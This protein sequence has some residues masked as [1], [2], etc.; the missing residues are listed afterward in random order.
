MDEANADSVRLGG[1]IGLAV[2]YPPSTTAAITFRV[3]SSRL[4]DG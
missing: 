2:D 4:F 1:A 3:I